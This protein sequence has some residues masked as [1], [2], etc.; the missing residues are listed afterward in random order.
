[1]Y[2]HLEEVDAGS[3]SSDDIW[4][5]FEVAAAT[6]SSISDDDDLDFDLAN[7]IVDPF[8]NMNDARIE[9]ELGTKQ[10]DHLLTYK[11]S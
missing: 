6:S 10:V 4:N 1:M 11:R 9:P 7:M 3:N 5:E 2:D 8:D